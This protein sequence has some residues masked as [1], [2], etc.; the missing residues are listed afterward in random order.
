MA[1]L[2]ND[3][4]VV[5]KLFKAIIFPCFGVSMVLI[6]DNGTH[7]IEKKL[8][9]LLK[10]YKVHCKYR[11]RCHPQTSVWV[12]ISNREIKSILEKR[13]T[14]SRKDWADKL[15]DTLWAHRTMFKTCIYTTPFRLIHGK[16]CHI[17]VE[18]EHRAFWAIKHFNFDLKSAGEKN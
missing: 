7:L 6:S 16:A 12:E 18:L 3:S 14:R 10:K 4:G 2:T 5:A 1:S 11:L 9:A 8:E 15:D 17:P 13:V